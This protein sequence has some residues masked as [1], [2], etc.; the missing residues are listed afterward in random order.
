VS[1]EHT[2]Q[3]SDAGLT[4]RKENPGTSPDKRQRNRTI[5]EIPKTELGLDKTPRAWANIYKEKDIDITN[6][7]TKRSNVDKINSQGENKAVS[8]NSD[9]SGMP[10]FKRIQ[11]RKEEWEQRAQQALKK[12]LP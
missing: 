3:N 11:Q 4:Y 9:D 6:S 2:T 8:G 7:E 1:N 5:P 10:R 12:T